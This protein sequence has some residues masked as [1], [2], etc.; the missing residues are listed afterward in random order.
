MTTTLK[1][2]HCDGE[3]LHLKFLGP[4]V[5]AK[6]IDDPQFNQDASGSFTTCPHCKRRVDFD[7]I[8]IEG[9]GARLRIR[10]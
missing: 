2:P 8:S 10:R 4:D 1:C 7:V 9:S 3:L 5:A 6:R